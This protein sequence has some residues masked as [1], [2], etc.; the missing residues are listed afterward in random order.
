MHFPKS[1]EVSV[2]MLAF[3]SVHIAITSVLFKKIE[4]DEVIRYFRSQRAI[5]G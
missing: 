1:L 2:P 5:N 3:S 4:L